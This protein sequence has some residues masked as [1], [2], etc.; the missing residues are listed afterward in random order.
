M[1]S[2]ESWRKYLEAGAALGQATAARAE[3]IVKGLFDEDE[4]ERES[5]WRDLEQLTRFGRLMGEQLAELAR[6]ELARQLKSLGGGSF[7]Q[8]FQRISDLLG[9][10]PPAPR[11]DRADAVLEA[12]VIGTGQPLEDETKKPKAKKQ[13]KQAG[14]EKGKKHKKKQKKKETDGPKQHAHQGGRVLTL[15]PT[16]HP[17]SES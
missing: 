14:A 10:N 17:S 11:E 13:T 6:A 2:N 15:E 4:D 7:D 1:T 3:D 12:I 9:G 8:L 16:P 5:A